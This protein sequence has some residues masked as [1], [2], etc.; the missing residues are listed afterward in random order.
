MS[1]KV[2]S[3]SKQLYRVYS[4]PLDKNAHFDNIEDFEDYLAGITAESGNIYSGQVV[5]VRDPSSEIPLVFV[6]ANVEVESEGENNH[7]SVEREFKAYRLLREIDFDNEASG[8]S[9][10][11]SKDASK[12]KGLQDRVEQIEAS[13]NED[14]TD[15]A[16]LKV[17]VDRVLT[18]NEKLKSKIQ[19]LEN[20][21][22][23]IKILCRDYPKS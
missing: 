17:D 16:N 20:E 13:R 23:A 4:G 3:F 6:I 22:E 21:I 11:I 19:E 14:N 10:I 9:A 8:L 7:P 1:N 2:T 18:E 5:S 15:I 12:I